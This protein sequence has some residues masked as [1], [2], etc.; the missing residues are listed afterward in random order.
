MFCLPVF[1]HVTRQDMII[2]LISIHPDDSMTPLSCTLHAAEI[3]LTFIPSVYCVVYFSVWL[4][5]VGACLWPP[6]LASRSVHAA[7]WSS[8]CAPWRA[9]GRG[10]AWRSSWRGSAATSRVPSGRKRKASASVVAARRTRHL[11]VTRLRKRT[12]CAACR[13][14]ANRCRYHWSSEDAKITASSFLSSFFC[15][16]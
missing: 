5:G 3:C 4:R 8:S 15:L 13:Y 10:W 12:I 6:S 7:R 2:P 14:C 11:A 16:F 9:V 1:Y